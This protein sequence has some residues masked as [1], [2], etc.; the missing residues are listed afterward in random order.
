MTVAPLPESLDLF[1]EILGFDDTLRLIEARGGTRFWVPKGIEG[2]SSA[3][4]ESFVAEFGEAMT[5][6]MIRGFGGG[7]ITVPLCADWRTDLYR[8]RG[9]KIREIALKLGC[10]QETVRRRLS[11]AKMDPED[12][13]QMALNF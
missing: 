9:L 2:S 13:K 11:R 12:R 5:K 3:L 10:H 1:V 4:H 8:Q 6:A 7:N